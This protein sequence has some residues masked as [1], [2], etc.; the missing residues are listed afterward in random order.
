MSTP[1]TGGSGG[2]SGGAPPQLVSGDGKVQN[3]AGH[4]EFCDGMDLPFLG[5]L[6]CQWMGYASG[7]V[8]C[9]PACD[10]F[11]FSNCVRPVCGDGRIEGLEEC[12]CRRDDEVR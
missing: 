4:W 8:K 7:R 3:T 12:D 11:D 6:T 5:T 1:C 10:N 2:G 9:T